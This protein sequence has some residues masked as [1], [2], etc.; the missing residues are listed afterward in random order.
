[1]KNTAVPASIT[2]C[3]DGKYRWVYEF[4]M[5][6]ESTIFFTVFKVLAISSLIPFLILVISN[7]FKDFNRSLKAFMIIVGILFILCVISY[8]LITLFYGGKYCIVFTMD[9][10]GITHAQQEKQFRKAQL[11]GVITAMAGASSGKPGVA[12]TG[13]LAASKS[14][15]YSDFGSVRSIRVYPKRNL[16]KLD[17]PTN[18]NQIY[19]EDDALAFIEKHIRENCTGVK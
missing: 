2:L 6:K 12:G 9:D 5:L 11:I 4:N 18:H 7:G 14:E 3:A 17:Y 1:M 19:C 15:L 16:I 8:V 10:K 13:I